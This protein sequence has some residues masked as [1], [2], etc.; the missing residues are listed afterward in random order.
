[1]LL[2]SETPHVR[3]HTVKVA[4]ID[5]ARYGFTAADCRHTMAQRVAAFEPLRYRLVEIP[6]KLHHPMWIETCPVD[7]D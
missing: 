3:M 7:V 2:Y 1:M 5:A 4:M 6:F